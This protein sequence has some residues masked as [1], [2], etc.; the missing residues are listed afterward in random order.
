MFKPAAK[1]ESN[2][3][4]ATC[5]LTIL[6]PFLFYDLNLTAVNLGYVHTWLKV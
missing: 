6:N 1:I 4:D 2:L 5:F 3:S